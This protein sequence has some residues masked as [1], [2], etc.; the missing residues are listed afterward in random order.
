MNFEQIT[1][2]TMNTLN[3]FDNII[4]V[5]WNKWTWNIPDWSLSCLR[6]MSLINGTKKSWSPLRVRPGESRDYCLCWAKLLLINGNS[7]SRRWTQQD[8]DVWRIWYV[9]N[10]LKIFQ[11]VY[12]SVHSFI[13]T[14]HK[15]S[16]RLLIFSNTPQQVHESMVKNMQWLLR[17]SVRKCNILWLL[18][19]LRVRCHWRLSGW[20]LK[21]LEEETQI[22]PR[23]IDSGSFRKEK[24][25]V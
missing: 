23:I 16:R 18:C 15:Y 6:I 19:N 14:D 17:Y 13:N 9:E 4:D 1:R 3:K 11:V 24:P 12:L 7:F 22:V 21:F 25:L 5:Y 10:R 8:N 20:Q 2:S